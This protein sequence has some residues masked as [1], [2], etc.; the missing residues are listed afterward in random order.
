MVNQL[1]D[2]RKSLADN[3]LSGHVK[4]A[5]LPVLLMIKI[6]LFQRA[7]TKPLS[8]L[9]EVGELEPPVRSSF[10]APVDTPTRLRAFWAP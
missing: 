7:A 6:G 10:C 8:F 5:R 2:N 4:G 3:T 1:C 9:D